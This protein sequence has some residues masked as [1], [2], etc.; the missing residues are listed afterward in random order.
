MDGTITSNT[1]LGNNLLEVTVSGGN[2]ANITANTYTY[3]NYEKLSVMIY[4]IGSYKVGIFLDSVSE[5]NAAVMDIYSGTDNS[6]VVR[7]GNIN[8]LT[9]TQSDGTTGTL[10]L[11]N[12]WGFYAKGNAYI[13]GHIVANSGRFANW[14]ISD[15]LY[16][17]GQDPSA[18]SITLSPAGRTVSTAIGGSSGSNT[19]AF[20]VKNVF[21]VTTAGALYSTSGKIGGWTIGANALSTQTYGADNSV[22][23]SNTNMASKDI[24]GRTGAD[25]R[26]TIGSHFGVTNTGALYCNSVNLTG[27]ITA[28][29]G[30][31]GGCS[32]TDGKL[33]VSEANI[34]GTLSASKISVSD[35]SAFSATIGGFA[36]NST[37]IH[38]SNVEVTSNADNSIALSSAD[39]TRTINSTSRTGLRFAIGDKFGVTGDGAIY[40][41]SATIS[42]ALTASSGAV[43]DFTINGGKLYTNNHSA[44]NTAADGVFL[45]KDY[46]SLGSGGVTY[47]N[48]QGTG[49]IG[50]WTLSTTYIRNGNIGNATNKTV[51][52]VYLGTDGLNIS[53]GTAAT[54]AYITKTAVNI[55]NKLTW[56]GTTLSV[57]G[58]ITANDGTIGGWD[59]STTSN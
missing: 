13:E 41:S 7:S 53:N 54:T 16:Y 46:I 27:T 36:I 35:L 24:G 34:S 28:T 2:A 18:T 40:A 1:N 10:A 56:D 42:G 45:S 52:G 59:I 33:Y 48:K 20:T 49:K 14:T 58:T 3:G 12:G 57:D 6:V 22:F 51:A 50:P 38:T 32:I 26:F 8:G 25:W 55:G 11:T 21:G 4:K 39:F 23:L 31:I 17:N 30:T 47:F 44:Y 29:G 37:S 43:G 5:N 9:Y 19:W 15:N